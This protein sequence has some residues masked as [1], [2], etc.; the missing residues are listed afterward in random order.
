MDGIE[1][2]RDCAAFKCT[3]IYYAKFDAIIFFVKLEKLER[4]RKPAG[5]RI[6]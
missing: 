3:R 5:F 1:G 6:K 2:E 4:K